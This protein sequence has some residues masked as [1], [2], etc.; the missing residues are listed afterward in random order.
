MAA[1]RFETIRTAERLAEIGSAWTALW[2]TSGALIFQSHAWISAWWASAPDRDRRALAVVVAWRGDR[3]VGVLPLATV[4]R[5]GFRV[6]EWAAKDCSDFGDALLA[7]WT[8]HALVRR[9]WRHAGQAG[10]FDLAYLNRLLPDAAARALLQP[11][12]GAVRLRL[13]HRD[14]AN[15]RVRGP[16]TTG[17]AWFDAQSKK[18]RQNYRRGQKFLS[19]RGPLAFR[20][21]RPDEPLGPVLDRLATFKRAWL[22]R[23][24][25]ASTAFYDLGSRA[26]PA[27][28]QVLAEAGLLH[29]FVLECG[30]AVVAVS[31]NFVQA[32]AMMAFVTTYD[33][34]VERASPGMVL[35]MDYIMWSIDRG[36][37][38]VD[39][40]CGDEGFKSRFGTEALTL[41]SMTGAR[42]PQGSA[43]QLVDRAHHA[44]RQRF[45]K[46][47]GTAGVTAAAAA[48]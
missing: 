23:H 8:D 15:W 17:Q 34:E 42:T 9:M 25:L 28:V 45:G 21:L 30:G 48:A 13:N 37:H 41:A 36:L 18:T 26:L 5:K 29:A 40:L 22:Q 7:D 20:Q 14:E 16:W 10:G 35:M 24:G 1:E 4:R 6:L 38:T 39:F 46:P 3:L 33:P 12:G 19:E 43:A 32:G 27:M 31:I 47:E 2:A 11:E 44:W